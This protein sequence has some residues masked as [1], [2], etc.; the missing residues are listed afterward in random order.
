MTESMNPIGTSLNAQPSRAA[1]DQELSEAVVKALA[2]HFWI[3]RKTIHAE[4]HDAWLSLSG[5]V[6]WLFQRKGVEDVVR[7]I[8]GLRGVS[9]DIRVECRTVSTHRPRHWVGHL[10]LD[11]HSKS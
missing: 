10:D 11:S 1:S 5:T 7:N 4:V 9:N 6:E 3:P 2:W 8:A